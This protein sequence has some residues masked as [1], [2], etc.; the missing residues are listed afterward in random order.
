[1]TRASRP[2]V[3]TSG[4]RACWQ[5][6]SADVDLDL[7]A[8]IAQWLVDDS[9]ERIAF[10]CRE[11]SGASFIA[12]HRSD[13]TFLC[14]FVEPKDVSFNYL[15][16]NRGHGLAVMATAYHSGWGDW[17]YGLYLDIEQLVRLGE[18]R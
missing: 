7:A 16:P 9:C 10:L 11:S 18:G 13:G 14:R 1:V 4:S 15:G 2:T 17:W 5:S 8:T 12:V 3:V 6:G